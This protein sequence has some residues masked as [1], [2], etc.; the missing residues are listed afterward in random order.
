ML[1]ARDRSGARTAI[2]CAKAAWTNY[3]ELRLEA[4]RLL[5]KAENLST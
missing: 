1:A 4:D 2:A 3:W 5:A